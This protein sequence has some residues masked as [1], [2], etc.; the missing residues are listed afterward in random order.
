MQQRDIISARR[1]QLGLTQLQVARAVG[2]SEA[3]VSRWES[4]DIAEVGSSKIAALARVLDMEPAQ[5]LGQDAPLT[6]PS[7][8]PGS[9]AQP[10]PTPTVPA[11]LR[12]RS[13]GAGSPVSPAA[14][15]GSAAQ[16]PQP[17]S[18]LDEYLEQLRTRPEMRMFFS[19]AKGA[20]KSEVED[21]AR[22]VEAYFAGRQAGQR[23]RKSEAE[24]QYPEEPEEPETQPEP[25]PETQPEPAQE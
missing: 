20:T 9:A 21:A 6:A 12:S 1:K 16:P 17:P 5:L 24:P 3:T 14:K 19:L 10:P 2:V 8:K 4:G 22:I 18:E 25:E 13:Q 11:S 23:Q 15:P 7:A